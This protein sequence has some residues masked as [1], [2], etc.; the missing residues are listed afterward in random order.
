MIAT[1]GDFLVTFVL[2][3]FYPNYNHL[4]LVMSEL[5]TV[6]SPVA[7]WIN[8]WWI[9]FG[10]LIIVFAFGYR[11][12][13]PSGKKSVRIVTLL[14]LLFG[15][16]AGIGAGLF[17]MEPGGTETTLTGKLHGICAGTGFI[18][19]MFV[20]LVSLGIFHRRSATKMYWSS[21]GAFLFGLIFFF[22]F[23]VSENSS[24]IDG[25]LGYTGLWQRL[26]LLSQYVYLGLISA[27]M[28]RYSIHAKKG[29]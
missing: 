24:S 8:L 3:F 25:I 23:V 11:K 4:T 19:I 5:G 14:I 6:Q 18:A 7:T 9:V 12:A 29:I 1:V 17:P 28:I 26:F 2:G 15:I 16:G 13:F 27:I 20:P 22:L 21:I 10:V